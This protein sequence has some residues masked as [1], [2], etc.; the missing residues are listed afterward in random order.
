M[1]SNLRFVPYVEAQVFAKSMASKE[2]NAEG[3]AT[4]RGFVP[5]KDGGGNVLYVRV[6]ACVSMES[7]AQSAKHVVVK[8]SAN[9]TSSNTIVLNAVDPPYVSTRSA[10]TNVPS[11]GKRNKLKKQN[12]Q[13]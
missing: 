8:Q 9:T 3:A 1:V 5:T 13:Q 2:T 7:S 10:G 4:E 11:V 6:R 12:K